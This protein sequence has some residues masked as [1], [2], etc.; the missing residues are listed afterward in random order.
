MAK[1]STFKS[2]WPKYLLQWGVLALLVFFLS[3]LASLVFTDM[4][5]PDPEK[6]CPFGGLEALGTYF[7]NGSLPC[8]MTS[9]QIAMGV[10]LAAAV[11][12]LGKL[13]CG[14]LCPVGT[15][16][17]L[18]KKLRQAIG[19]NAFNINERSVADKVLRIVKYV[20]L[21]I[22]FYMTLTASELFC[23]NFDPYYATATGFK[24]EITLW[25]SVAALALVLIPGLFVDGRA[26]GCVVDSWPSR[27]TAALGLAAWSHVSA[28]L[29]A[30]DPLRKAKA[31]A[32]RR[33][34]RQR[35]MQRQLPSLPEELSL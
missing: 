24:G 5:A 18:L 8:S 29:P 33:G 20:L 22:T 6:Y 15:V 1:K 19:F 11:V 7:A 13:F 10:V 23:K 28:R 14:Y 17:D 26:C 30:G 34:Y 3:G 16:E 31:S 27:T 25:M 21:F 32:A 12:L 4:N 9:M 2:N 35:Q